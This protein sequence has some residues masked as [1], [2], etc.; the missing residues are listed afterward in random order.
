MKDL[1]ILRY[2]NTALWKK[3][4]K[5]MIR[6][7]FYHLPGYHSLAEGR[8]EGIA[9]L[10]VYREKEYIAA[11]PL[12][13]R[14]VQNVPG[15]EKAGKDLWDATSVYGYAGPVTS[16]KNLPESFILNFQDSI[17]EELIKQNV[18]T[19]FSRL[20]PFIP[21]TKLLQGIGK[22]VTAGI[23]ISIDLTLSLEEQRSQYSKGH[24]SGVNKLKKLNAV[25]IHDE[26]LEYFD[27]FIDLYYETMNRVTAKNYYYFEKSY[28]EKFIRQVEDEVHLF[29]C[30]LDNKMMCG[31]LYVKCNNILQSFLGG[32]RDEFRKISPRKLEKDTVRIW[33]K[34]QGIQIFHLGGGVGGKKDSLY[35]FKS[36]FSKVRHDF[37]V[38]KWIVNPVLYEKLCKGKYIDLENNTDSASYFPAYRAI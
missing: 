23:T 11:L 28:F 5:E 13:L 14:K 37:H 30:L 36:G 38:W 16:H 29:V 8:G 4:I 24:K 10:Y 20:H 34:E 32:M 9:H 31:G 19:V 21:Q 33:A 6:Y 15:L 27:E 2:E 1:K 17:K 26:R 3:T 7:D 25:C 22:V 12:L 35:E 18:I